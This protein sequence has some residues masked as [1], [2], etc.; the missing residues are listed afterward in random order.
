MTVEKSRD[1]EVIA[2][3]IL[4]SLTY[5]IAYAKYISINV[6]QNTSNKKVL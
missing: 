1:G 4:S 3:K 2:K 6:A 5:Q